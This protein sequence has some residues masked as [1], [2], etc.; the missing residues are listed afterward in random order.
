M[1]DG[2]LYWCCDTGRDTTYVI[3]GD[4][5]GDL[6]DPA[7]W[8]I[9]D[10]LPV[11]PS[12]TRGRGRNRIL[13]GNVVDVNGRL[14]CC[15]ET[16]ECLEYHTEKKRNTTMKARR[17][18]VGV[19]ILAG[20]VLAAAPG[21]PGSSAIAQ[22]TA[23]RSE[24]DETRM[25]ALIDF[26]DHALEKARDRWSGE[27]T[28]LFAD[29]LEVRTGQPVEWLRSGRRYVI[30]NLASQQN[31]FRTLVALSNLIEDERYRQAAKDATAHVF[32]H[33]RSPCGLLYWGGHTF[34][35]LR[36]LEVVHIEGPH[37]EIKMH[38][39]YYDLMWQVDPQ[40]TAEFIRA[41]WN[42]NLRGWGRLEINRHARY[43]QERGPLW[44]SEWE[45]PEPL[46]A[47]PWSGS[48]MPITDMTY[49][50]GWLAHQ[51]GERGALVWA[52]RL[53]GLVDGARHPDTRLGP[54]RPTVR[55]AGGSA[56]ADQQ[57]RPEF[58]DL[59]KHAWMIWGSQPRR[60]Y[61]EYA[62]AQMELAE[63]L[64]EEGRD[65]LS[66]PLEG[67]KAYARH[68]YD[69]E[70]NVFRAMWA[71]GTDMTGYVVKRSGD[72]PAGH[73]IQAIPADAAFLLSS[74]RAW[75][76]SGDP[77]LWETVRDM[78]RGC[79]LGD[80]GSAAEQGAV[81]D[82]KTDCSDAQALL[83]ILELYRGSGQ[84]PHL[85]LARRIGDN[86]V[87]HRFRNNLFVK[88]TQHRYARFDALEPLA[89]LTLEAAIRGE[90]EQV[91]AFIG[92]LWRYL[93]GPY[94]GH[95]RA[96]DQRLFYRPDAYFRD[97][98]EIGN[99]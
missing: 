20:A 57:F 53:R 29:A 1:R 64:G 75:R 47:T 44:D 70:D 21:Q 12:L 9:S 30:S 11:P 67:L 68:A 93:Q 66:F 80:L 97:G 14:S 98:D 92:G 52:E 63:L 94:D 49:S 15:R 84:T 6:T 89:L 78:A 60:I 13:E 71:D 83:A 27:D 61:V 86:I 38:L 16:N 23:L 73:V 72:L 36:T 87:R 17:F 10:G 76:I 43:G 90:P 69:A 82:L 95:G 24:A 81:P 59:A 56:A 34:I 3:A 88:S 5:D 48:L 18:L 45:D 35:D 42:S 55:T 65:F 22:E 99:D 7:A 39:P 40:A 41:Y 31:F 25:Q 74:A 62:L 2:Q 85:S 96:S 77:E 51:E 50:A 54:T 28:P 32:E 91:P 8:R 58:G 33:F 37:M 19:G 79:G 26:A 46:Y 4:L